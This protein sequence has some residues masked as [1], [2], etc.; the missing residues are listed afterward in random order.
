MKFLSP[1]TSHEREPVR[2]HR[3]Q[4][5]PPISAVSV[6]VF[7]VNPNFPKQR[8]IARV[9]E[10]IHHFQ[11]SREPGSRS[12]SLHLVRLA[13]AT[14]RHLS[15]DQVGQSRHCAWQLHQWAH[16]RGANNLASLGSGTGTLV[17]SYFFAVWPV[18]LVEVVAKHPDSV[19]NCRVF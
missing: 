2:S 16:A 15:R 5:G 8:P 19:P 7:T 18:V 11:K 13:P 6:N 14:L 17:L 9:V 4:N 10:S 12:R 1:L 3:R